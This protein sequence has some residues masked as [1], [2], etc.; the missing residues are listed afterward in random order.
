MPPYT[1]W[2]QG[3]AAI[4]AWLLGRGIGCRGSRLVPTRACGLPAFGQY[5]LGDDGVHRPWSLTVVELSGDRVA[6][7]NAFL[8]TDRLFPLFGLPSSLGAGSAEAGR[9]IARD[10]QVPQDRHVPADPGDRS[11]RL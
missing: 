5:R 4:K 2:L 7:W 6:R 3:R 8:D 10:G 9:H 1:L 11:V